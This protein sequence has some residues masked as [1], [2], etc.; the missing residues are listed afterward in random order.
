MLLGDYTALN[1]ELAGLGGQLQPALAGEG[2]NPPPNTHSV[3]VCFFHYYHK[4]NRDKVLPKE[5]RFA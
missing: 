5:K 4:I 2:R 1:L 3:I